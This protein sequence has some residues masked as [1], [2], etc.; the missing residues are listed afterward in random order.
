MDQA[1]C[2]VADWHASLRARSTSDTAVAR[3]DRRSGIAAFNATPVEVVQ[4]A[5]FDDV[6]CLHRG[7]AKRVFRVRDGRR[8]TFDVE[9]DSSTLLQRGQSARWRTEGPIDYIHLTIG[10][11]VFAEI[12]RAESGPPHALDIQ[13]ADQVGFT[14]PLLANLMIEMLKVC[15]AGNERLAAQR[16][17]S[18]QP[19]PGTG[20]SH[21]C[22]Q[23]RSDDR[24]HRQRHQG[25]TG[26]V[27]VAR[28]AGVHR[29]A[30]HHRHF[31]RQSGAR[32]G[33]E[34]SAFLSRVSAIDRPDAGALSGKTQG[35]RRA[36]GDRARRI[37]CSEIAAATGFSSQAAIAR[38]F[39]RTL[40]VTP[41]AYR[42]RNG[43]RI[44]ARSLRVGSTRS[45]SDAAIDPCK[46]RPAP[47][48]DVDLHQA[49]RTGRSPTEVSRTL[50][51]S[52][53][54]SRR[55]ASACA[56]L[57]CARIVANDRLALATG[58]PWPVPRNVVGQG[59]EAVPVVGPQVVDALVPCDRREPL[60]EGPAGLESVPLLVQRDEHNPLKASPPGH[61]KSVLVP[62]RHHNRIG[63]SPWGHLP[64]SKTICRSQIIRG[65]DSLKSMRLLLRAYESTT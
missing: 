63:S 38:A 2:S 19:D 49:F 51:P 3:E 8:A 42:R 27:A 22:E 53:L 62:I 55:I 56:G 24:D 18:D 26:R 30:P 41:D 32:V 9:R 33:L 52:I 61:K 25:R 58:A 64:P 65:S 16:F 45:A 37:R 48:M 15:A 12:A 10:P 54:D 60:S 40:M 11:E 36:A 20:S 29:H 4:P 44:T 23:L 35:R 5:L 59:I 57:S 17:A 13:F 14:D 6:L 7:G 47:A 31:V 21:L 43:V 28:G 39:R 34:P 46:I 50:Y 1:S